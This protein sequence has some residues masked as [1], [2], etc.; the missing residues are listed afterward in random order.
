[1]FLGPRPVFMP[2]QHSPASERR[3]AITVVLVDDEE[4]VRTALARA[5]DEHGLELI[6]EA[7]STQDAINL[8]VDLRPD[9]VLMDPQVPGIAGID[10]IKQL[11]LLAPASRTLILTR[12]G[13]NQVV[14]SIVA[15]A[16]GYILKTAPTEAIIG[17]IRATA[18]GES[19]L[20]PQIAGVLLERIRATGVT[21][22]T[23]HAAAVAIR[24][25]LTARELEIFTQLASGQTNSEIGLRLALSTNTVSNHIASI[26]TKLR[27]EN[28]IQAAVESV[29][30]GIA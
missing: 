23:D 6:G 18:A 5:L 17:A 13:Q 14:E 25:A 28:R 11:Y 24:A 9:V 15:G 8:V 1:M 21:D 30:S 29:R 26:L 16:S 27:L 3:R 7:S 20:S 22:T 4:L 10:A 19:V 12:N 2:V